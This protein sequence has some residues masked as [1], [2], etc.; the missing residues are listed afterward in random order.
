M[1]KPQSRVK[2]N[3]DGTVTISLREPLSVGSKR[4]EELTFQKMRAKHMRGQTL[5]PGKIEWDLL[6]VVASRLTGEA[7]PVLGELAGAD[8]AD[9]LEVTNRFLSSF[10]PTGE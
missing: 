3:E 9:V 10:L 1:S 2:E 8:L 5:T 7:P 6:I 4:I